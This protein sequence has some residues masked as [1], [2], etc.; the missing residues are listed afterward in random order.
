VPAGD[1]FEFQKPLIRNVKWLWRGESTVM[2]AMVKAGEADISWDVGVDAIKALPKELIRSGGS[3]EVFTLDILSIWHPETSKKKV[4]QA[5]AHAINCQELIDSLYGGNSVCR[6]NIIWPG[7]IGATERNT[8]PYKYDPV[9]ARQLLQEANYNPNNKITIMG[10]GTRI[11]KQVEVYE[12]IQGYL[13]TVGMNVDI[14]VIEVK[15]FI[16]HRNC[17]A[18]KAVSEILKQRGRD[19]DTSLATAE[20]FQAAVNKGGADCPTAELMENEPSNE[21]LDFGRQAIFY[22]NCAR[23]ASPHCDPSPGGLQEQLVPAIAAS[24]EERRRR[25][26]ALADRVHDDVL[27]MP[28][29]DLPVIYAVNP[30]LNWKPRFDRRMRISTMWFSK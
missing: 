18:G 8:A 23:I 22:L 30:K 2:A 15:A 12:A 29:F 6:G 24:G 3:A 13:K 21:T 17:R 20:E 4:R 10:R 25:L 28:A 5:M 7:V 19:V 9:L 14:K 16:D 11:P 26:E 1:H 27:W